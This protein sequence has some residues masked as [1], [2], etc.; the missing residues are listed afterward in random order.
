MNRETFEKLKRRK[1]MRHGDQFVYVQIPEDE[2]VDLSG[3]RSLFVDYWGRE[4]VLR[5]KLAEG[6]QAEIYSAYVPFLGPDRDGPDFR[7]VV[8]VFKGGSVLEHLEKQIPPALMKSYQRFK[9]GIDRGRHLSFGIEHATLLT[10]GKFKDRF[11]FVMEEAWGDL[12]KLVDHQMM[13]FSHNQG[14]PFPLYTTLHLMHEIADQMNNLHGVHPPILHNDLK[15]ANVLVE[16][17]ATTCGHRTCGPDPSTRRPKF[18]K[19]NGYGI[20]VADFECSIGVV[21]TGYWRAPEIL[22]QL[23][24]RVPMS[25]LKFSKACDVYSYGMTCYE[26]VSGRIPFEDYTNRPSEGFHLVLKGDRPELPPDLDPLV[27][28]II[29]SCWDPIPSKRP[30]FEDITEELKWIV[31][32]SEG[33]TSEGEISEGETSPGE[34]SPVTQRKSVHRK[35]VH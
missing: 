29:T 17:D 35:S 33:E 32:S 9:N 2:N 26:L 30:S 19:E 15:A 20:T 31:E 7:V 25:D 10:R 21:G 8:K 3:H 13:H 18:H 16:L 14:P 5:E 22:Q 1:Y 28:G 4:V 34:T 6:G 11:A 23:K 24:D 12:R 27:R